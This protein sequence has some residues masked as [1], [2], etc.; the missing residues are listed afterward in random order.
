MRKPKIT[1]TIYKDKIGYSAFA[2]VGKITILTTGDDWDDLQRMIL[3]AVNLA[4]E[5]EGITYSIDEIKFKL[6]L[7][8]FFQ[9]YKVINA[10]ALG[11]RIGMNQSLLAQYIKGIKKPSAKQTRR[12]MEGVQQLGKELAEIEFLIT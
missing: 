6:D 2:S 12:I 9:F 8:S 3:D 5:E 1:I 4:F 7:E 11:E 10:K